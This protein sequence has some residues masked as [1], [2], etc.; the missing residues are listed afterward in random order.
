[1]PL[2]EHVFLAR[3]DVSAQQVETLTEQFKTVIEEGGGSIDKAEYWGLRSLAYKIKK[4][5]KAHYQ[6]LNINAPHPAVAEME[7][8]MRLNDDVVRFITLRV[9]EHESGP[10]VVMQNKGGRDDRRGPRR[11]RNDRPERSA[12]AAASTETPAVAAPATKEAE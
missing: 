10:S 2:Y 5:R 6:L 11:D 12:P 3:Q 1:M 7:R 4:Y 9:D 8:Q